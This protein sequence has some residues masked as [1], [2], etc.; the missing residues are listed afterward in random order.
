MDLFDRIFKLHNILRYRNTPISTAVLK[1]KLQCSRAT[2]ARIVE[3]LR[4]YL[5]APIAYDRSRNGYS[6]D[7]ENGEH[8]WRY[9]A[10]RSS[11]SPA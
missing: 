7:P 2:V 4:D 11:N 5:G 3:A 1:D 10:M 8:L 9:L 6:Y